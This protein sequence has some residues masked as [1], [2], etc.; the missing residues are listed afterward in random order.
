MCKGRDGSG[1][2]GGGRLVEDAA[3]I[4]A[5]FD[6][7]GSF[8]DLDDSRDDAWHAPSADLEIQGAMRVALFESGVDDGE[9]L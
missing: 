3:E 7:V 8:D 4:S 1:A 9:P 5:A 6:E 2:G